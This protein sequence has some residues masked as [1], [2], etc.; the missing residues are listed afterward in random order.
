MKNFCTWGLP[1][2]RGRD[3]CKKIGKKILKKNHDG[4]GTLNSKSAHVC[5]W[6]LEQTNKALFASARIKIL[7]FLINSKLW[8]WKS[9]HPNWSHILI[10]SQNYK[11]FWQF[12]VRSRTSWACPCPSPSISI[13]SNL[14]LDPT[15]MLLGIYVRRQF[16]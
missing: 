2:M 4:W 11:K 12:A 1:A 3:L 14:I 5:Y 16:W 13:S 15:Y 6:N 7:Q 9:V 8:S 10:K